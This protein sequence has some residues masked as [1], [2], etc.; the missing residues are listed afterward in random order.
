AE[1]QRRAEHG[2]GARSGL[3]AAGEAPDQDEAVNDEEEACEIAEQ[4]GVGELGPEDAAV[5]GGEIGG[6]EQAADD[7]RED[8]RPARQR[9]AAALAPGD[10]GEQRRRQRQPPEAGGDRPDMAF[11]AREAH[12]PR[13]KREHEIGE[14][15]GGKGKA[16][17]GGLVHFVLKPLYPAAATPNQ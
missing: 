14:Q 6:E 1:Q 10:E 4:R 17:G 11:G 7:D 5:P 8:Q 15:Q 16:L 13:A 2:E 12:Q 3:E 9:L